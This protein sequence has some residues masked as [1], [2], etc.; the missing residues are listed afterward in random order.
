MCIQAGY[1][2]AHEPVPPPL[3]RLLHGILQMVKRYYANKPYERQKRMI[4]DRN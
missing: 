2:T 3:W 1:D 4:Y